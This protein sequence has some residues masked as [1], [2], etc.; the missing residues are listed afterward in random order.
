MLATI[1]ILSI[2]SYN[3][4]NKAIFLIFYISTISLKSNIII[5]LLIN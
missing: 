4:I 2:E 3:L 1:T 5:I